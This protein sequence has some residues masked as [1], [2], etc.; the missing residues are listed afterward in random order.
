M[1][2]FYLPDWEDRLDPDFD[3]SIDQ[4]SQGHKTSPYKNDVYAHQLF[5]E[6]PYDGILFSL[7]VF[8]SKITLTNGNDNTFKIRDATN[9]KQYLKIPPNSSLEVMGDCG[10]FGYVKETIP[11]LPFYSVKNV[12]N[13]YEKLGFDYG[14]SVDHL[15]VDYVLIKNKSENKKK[16]YLSV[17]EKKERV[18]ITRKNANEFFNYHKE[19]GFKFKPIGVAQGYDLNSYFMSVANIVEIGYEYIAIGSLVSKPSSFIISILNKIQPLIEEKHIHLFGVIRPES[20]DTFQ[21]L[22]VTS[23]DSASFLRKAWLRS[24]QNY[25]A[26][27]GKW[28]TA[29]RVPQSDNKKLLKNAELNGHSLND[30]KVMEKKALNALS[31]YD[32]GNLDLEEALERII[33][34]DE[35]LIRNDD[36]E[37]KR[38]KYRRTLS[39][40]PWRS[41]SCEICKELGIQ[42]LI[43]RGC[44]RNKRRGLHNTWILTQSLK[45]H[46][47]PKLAAIK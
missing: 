36:I 45:N 29:I 11:P 13:L 22:G 1:I 24:G 6:S 14:V 37:S 7:S 8:Q 5:Q 17:K 16:K 44:N 19:Q 33:E 39:E 34:Y 2:K 26:S 35:L 40:K 21:K 31:E 46:E 18:E 20:I 41:C 42:T 43:F 38:D 32:N 23:I 47:I 9:I 4:Y 10:A 30:L 25:L 28:Y 3:F 27:N 15:V 12:A